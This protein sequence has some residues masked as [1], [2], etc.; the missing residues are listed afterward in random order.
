LQDLYGLKA[1]DRLS[2]PIA[3]REQPVFVAGIWRDYVRPGGALVMERALYI[4]LTGDANVTEAALW[5]KPG[6]NA[7]AFTSVVQAHFGNSTALELVST[8]TVRSR[9]LQIFDRAFAMTYA[10]EIIAVVIGLVGVA[11]AASSTALARRAQFGMLRHLGMLRAQVLGMLAC[12]GL[13]MSALGVL[14]GLTLGVELSLV[15]IYV[16]NRQSFNWS[17]DLS[18]PW[19]SL[20]ALSG[21]LIA[22]VTLTA[23]WSGRAALGEAALRA[24]RED[25]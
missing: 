5:L 7:A 16:I 8:D 23:V 2:L 20:A 12:D 19:G 24:V 15:L 22:A 14:Y 25:W 4:R 13:F 18:V 17:I 21:A 11:V 3:G 6:A 10:L 9:S 1:G